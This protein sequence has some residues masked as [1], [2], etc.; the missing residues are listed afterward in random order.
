MTAAF[1]GAVNDFGVI[2]LGEATQ[3]LKTQARRNHRRGAGQA[4]NGPK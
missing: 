3:I 4:R 2:I 1:F